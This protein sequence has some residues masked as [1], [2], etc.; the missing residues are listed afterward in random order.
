MPS[1]SSAIG[2]FVIGQS[3]I[4]GYVQNVSPST[5][6]NTILAYLYQ[7]YNDDADLQAFVSA[8]NTLTQGYVDW[9]NQINLPIY[10]GLSA[11]MLDWVAEG[12]YGITRPVLSSGLSH[13]IGPFNTYA[14]NSLTFDGRKTIPAQ[15]YLSTS[16]DI[17]KRIITWN[18]YKGDGGTFD[19]RWLKR[20]V[21]RFLTGMN[22]TSPNIDQT[23]PIDVY[24]VG[25]TEVIINIP[26]YTPFDVNVLAAFQEGINSGV[27][28]T[29][30]QFK[31]LAMINGVSA[32]F[33]YISFGS[34][35]F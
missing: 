31:F 15:N 16:D 6:Q 35:P 14:F 9:F 28:Q 19:V 13:K 2:S 12:L 8:Y 18:F 1:P 26:D 7:Q 17:F 22:G 32:G 25:A 21:M 29:P 30:F 23:Y 5:L 33:G 20:R 3:P 11:P 27:L 4:Q 24:A 34:S 10:T